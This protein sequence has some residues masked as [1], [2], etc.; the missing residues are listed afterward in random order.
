[1]T[2]TPMPP[3]PIRATLVLI[4]LCVPHTAAS[5]CSDAC[6]TAQDGS[7][8]DGAHGAS[9]LGCAFGTDC[10]DCGDRPDRFACTGPTTKGEL[11]ASL[12]GPGSGY[13]R[14]TRPAEARVRRD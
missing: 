3:K 11:A 12:Y 1:M 2:P 7:C 4:W 8:D 14:Y 13:D 10:T 9:T 6:G 5:R